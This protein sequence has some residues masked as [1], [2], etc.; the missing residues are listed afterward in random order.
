L[1]RLNHLIHK[2]HRK[3]GI[4]DASADVDVNISAGEH[5]EHHLLHGGAASAGIQEPAPGSPSKCIEPDTLQCSDYDDEFGSDV[6][7][8]VLEKVEEIA[9]AFNRTQNVGSN[10]DA[11]DK[12]STSDQQY[13]D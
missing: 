11:Q 7:P 6:D 4:D 1:H 12:S 2:V 9:A 5:N 13:D 3:L 8:A 10:C